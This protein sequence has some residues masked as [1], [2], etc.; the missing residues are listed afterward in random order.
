[1]KNAQALRAG[2][3]VFSLPSRANTVY[4][5]GPS[6]TQEQQTTS[7]CNTHLFS[8]IEN[9]LVSFVN[10]SKPTSPSTMK[11]FL[12]TVALLAGSAAAFTPASA[13]SKTSALSYSQYWTP[14]ER[15]FAYGLPGSIA[16]IENF[17]PLGFA[18]GADLE[19]MKNYREAELQHGRA[20][21]LGALGMLVTEK[22][23][24]VR[25][26]LSRLSLG[27]CVCHRA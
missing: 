8:Q 15:E 4:D 17:D 10:S 19:K 22:P 25:L 12:S 26:S 16:P 27:F 9:Y 21:M 3:I 5:V 18:E 2:G 24:E 23:I 13:P 1:M 11:F 20:A 7:F 6:V 14:N